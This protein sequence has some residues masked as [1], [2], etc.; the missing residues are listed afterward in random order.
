[1]T[2]P[3]AVDPYFVTL[4]ERLY[5]VQTGAF[6]PRVFGTAFTV[7][8]NMSIPKW[9][10]LDLAV[11]PESPPHSRLWGRF[12]YPLTPCGLFL[13][14]DGTVI[15]TDTWYSDHFLTAD[16]KILGGYIWFTPHDSWQ[17]E[18]LT[19]AGYPLR[20]YEGPTQ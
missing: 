14:K 13:W 16:D 8:E 3:P 9:G 10:R 1:M 19:A 20:R 12:Q 5:D 15:L 6:D 2:V 18:V 7:P 11:R 4:D 17:A